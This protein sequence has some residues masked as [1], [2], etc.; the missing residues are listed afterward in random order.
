[1]T[2]AENYTLAAGLFSLQAGEISGSWPIFAAGAMVT[3]LP[4]L[5][6]FFI[7]Q[8]HML[9]GLTVGGVKG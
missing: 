9:S 6:I 1:M 4:I 3:S 5:I 8:R 2:G 7:I